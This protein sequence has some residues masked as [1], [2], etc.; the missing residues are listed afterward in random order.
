MRVAYRESSDERGVVTRSASTNG[1]FGSLDTDSATTAF[2][3]SHALKKS[4]TVGGE[5]SVRIR[6]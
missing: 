1:K 3:H 5:C 2:A 4:F 6:Q